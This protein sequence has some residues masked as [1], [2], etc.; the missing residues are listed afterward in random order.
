MPSYALE[1]GARLVII[2]LSSTPLDRQA[3]MLIQGK[4]GEVMSKVVDRVKEKL[5]HK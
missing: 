1:S 2:N 3:T 4:A 5:T